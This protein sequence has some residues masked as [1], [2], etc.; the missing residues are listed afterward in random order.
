MRK[1]N[2]LLI[3]LLAMVFVLF[4]ACDEDSSTSPTS[5]NGVVKQFTSSTGG[6][7]EAKDGSE[8]VVPSGAIAKSETGSDGVIT[9]SIETNVKELPTPIPSAY[10]LVGGV[11]HFGPASFVFTE[12]IRIWLAASSLDNLDNIV[13]IKYSE[14]KSEWVIVPISDLDA[15]NK[16]IGVSEYELG[17]Y[18]VAKKIVGS[19][20]QPILNAAGESGGIR[21][22]HNFTNDYYYTLFVGAFVPK[23]AQDAGLINIGA[24]SSTGSQVTGGPA[25]KTYMSF[26]PQGNYQ[27]IVARVKRGSFS[28]PPGAT[29][30]YSVPVT[31]NVNAFNKPLGWNYENYTPWSDLV[32]TGGNWT[33]QRP[34]IVPTPTVPFGTGEF[35]ATLTWL[36]T[37]GNGTDLDLHLYGPNG[38]HVYYNNETSSDGSLMLD[39]DWMEESG[40][41]VE[42]IFSLKSMPKGEYKVYVNVF[43]GD[44]PKSFDVRIIRNGSTVKT[45]RGTG[46]EENAFGS[47]TSMMLI[48]KFRL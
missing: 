29:E 9:F 46:T 10:S 40:S 35:Q 17:Y 4:P 15:D 20:K 8:I 2:L 36:N 25:Y 45:Y 33:S 42:N 3:A 39:R 22:T 21:L 31:V 13:V 24:N 11:Y 12:P 47:E 7:L 5:N 28:S 32:M 16:R 6:S 26:I 27:I 48:E 44:V 30:Y 23:Y 18:A 14:Y 43:S 19:V 41:A 34:E 37:S 1:Q 38:I